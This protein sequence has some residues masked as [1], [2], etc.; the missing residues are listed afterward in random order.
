MNL[1]VH[2]VSSE[3]CRQPFTNYLDNKVK[4]ISSIAYKQALTAY[5]QGNWRALVSI[6][7]VDTKEFIISCATDNQVGMMK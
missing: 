7:N 5:T 4:E 1:D 6:L 3:E 2:K